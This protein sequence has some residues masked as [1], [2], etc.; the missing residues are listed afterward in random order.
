MARRKDTD[1]NI[2]EGTPSVEQ[3]ALAVLMDI[4]DE[5]K[6]SNR[7]LRALEGILGCHNVTRGMMALHR[8]DRRVAKH[9]PLRPKGKKR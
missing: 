8:L 9:W 5:L 7:H 1:W 6:E 3:A 2:P 4:R